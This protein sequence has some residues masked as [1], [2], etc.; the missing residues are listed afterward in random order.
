MIKP[1][2]IG[3]VLVKIGDTE[4]FVVADF[5]SSRQV[6]LSRIS[7]SFGRLPWSMVISIWENDYVKVGE[8][9]FENEREIDDGE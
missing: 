7:Q 3:D 8:W 1:F 5:K 2:K 6:C 9:D 4:K